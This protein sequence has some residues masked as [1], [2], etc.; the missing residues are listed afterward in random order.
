MNVL[1]A[2]FLYASRSEPQAYTLLSTLL[3][4]HLPSYITPSMTGVHRALALLSRALAYLDPTLNAHLTRK[5]VHTE[6]YAFASILTLSACTP[7]LSEVLT[8]WDFYFAW[9]V[10]LNVLAVVAQ[11]MLMRDKIL[12]S[13]NPGKELR[14][15]PNLQA[16]K[17]ISLV[18]MYV[19][20][21]KEGLWND[22]VTHTEL[23]GRK[24][25]DRKELR[26]LIEQQTL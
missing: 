18:V 9:G 19:A 15:L 21:T 1:A 10:H 8:L 5:N 16:K 22:L 11:L 4:T 12:A 2:P 3:Q 17:I 14:T 26:T 25:S 6:T 7:P 13:E 23:D 24:Q 20:K